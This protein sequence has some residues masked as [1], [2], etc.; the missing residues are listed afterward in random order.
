MRFRDR[1]ATHPEV[2]REQIAQIAAGVADIAMLER[3]PSFEG[4]SMFA[5]LARGQAHA[6]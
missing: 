2:A 5:I 1:E 3:P 4:R 6:H